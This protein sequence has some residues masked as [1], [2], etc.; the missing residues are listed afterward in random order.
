MARLNTRYR[1]KVCNCQAL[2][3]VSYRVIMEIHNF[4]F[5]KF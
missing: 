2:K 5:A 4:E 3:D 1:A